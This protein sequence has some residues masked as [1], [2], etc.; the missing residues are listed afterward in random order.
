MVRGS[1]QHQGN[2]AK[3]NHKNNLPTIGMK[4]PMQ[5]RY[6]RAIAKATQQRKPATFAPWRF[7]V[8]CGK[9]PQETLQMCNKSLIEICRNKT[10]ETEANKTS[11]PQ[12]LSLIKCALSQHYSLL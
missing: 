9:V 7:A 11:Q 3:G 4:Q 2:K 5:Y 12:K 8:R 6:I 10:T 1:W